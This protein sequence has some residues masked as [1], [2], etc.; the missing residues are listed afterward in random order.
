MLAYNWH[1]KPHRLVYELVAEVKRL[2]QLVDQ[3]NKAANR[4]ADYL[5]LL[6]DDDNLMTGDIEGAIFESCTAS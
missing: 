2:R 3:M 4:E 5:T 1:D 6:C